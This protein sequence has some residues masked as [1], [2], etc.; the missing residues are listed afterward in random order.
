MDTEKLQWQEQ[1]FHQIVEM[2]PNAI[3][4]INEQ[5]IIEVANK[6]MEIIFG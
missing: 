2:A 4:L 1:Q 6:Q 5:G 3:A